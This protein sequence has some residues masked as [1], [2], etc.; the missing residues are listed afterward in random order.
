M[1]DMYLILIIVIAVSLVILWMF[2]S[3]PRLTEQNEY[4]EKKEDLFVRQSIGILSYRII[5]NNQTDRLELIIVN[6]KE[7]KISLQNIT[8]QNLAYD[9]ENTKLEKNSLASL[10][11]TIG[12]KC[13]AGD[14]YSY[15]ISFGFAQNESK[16]IF[17]FPKKL[18]GQCINI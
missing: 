8:I 17:K 11:F 10:N 2:W 7:T 3:L 1:R 6:N 5:D 14:Y 18:E 13:T 4:K 12:Q 9:L 16:H 15:S